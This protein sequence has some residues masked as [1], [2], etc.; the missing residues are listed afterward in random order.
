[1][2]DINTIGLSKLSI[3]ESF[4]GNHYED[5]NC[6]KSRM[7]VV[8]SMIADNNT[9]DTRGKETHL[10]G[11]D[12]GG[13]LELWFYQHAYQAQ[14]WIRSNDTSMPFLYGMHESVI[15]E[16]RRTVDDIIMEKLNFNIPLLI[17]TEQWN[18]INKNMRIW[19]Y[20]H[21]H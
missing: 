13:P 16:H 4:W 12:N 3:P 7:H 21:V 6:L 14:Q 9:P 20:L 8:A 18:A 1:M 19:R 11:S 10:L 17:S 15:D 5:F 2:K